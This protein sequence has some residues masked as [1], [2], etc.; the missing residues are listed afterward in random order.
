MLNE[1]QKL[2]ALI[3][4]GTELNQVNDLDLLL[5][6]L[7]TVARKF[8]NADA[9]TVYVR[10]GEDFYF[11]LLQNDTQEGKGDDAK[12]QLPGAIFRKPV[13]PDSIA[14][15]VARTGEFLNIP[16][17]HH[18]PTDAPYS[19]NVQ[20]DNE[21]GYRTGSMLT[22][23]LNNKR[24]LPLGILQIINAHDAD[25][26]IVSFSEAD[27]RIM[28]HFA[29]IAAIAL[30]RAQMTRALL[31]RM[32]RMAELRDPKE[33]G[34]HVNRV[35]SFSVALY[36]EW[37]KRHNIPEDEVVR[38]RDILRMA[39]ML[40]DAGKVG[41][42]DSILKKPGRLTD[43]ERK[44]MNQHSLFGAQLF[45]DIQSDFDEIASKVA[46]N[47]HENWDGT[48]YPGHID[49][50]TGKPLQGYE[51]PDGTA[52]GKIGDETP[53]F[54]RIVKLADVYDALSSQRC[55]KPAWDEERVLQVILEESGTS[56]DPELVEIFMENLDTM[57][58]I[59]QRY[60]E[61]QADNHA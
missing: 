12:I 29:T 22:I 8:V 41:I 2:D 55:Y 26:N 18:I 9:G 44:I 61:D 35:G 49:S 47:H 27:E 3:R 7:L 60:A 23:P 48:G 20:Y 21:S 1:Q 46:L 19:F 42:S 38:W 4:L 32:I 13:R 34:A 43:E 54:G 52:R 31:L 40:H 56:F 16:D 14:G 11:F 45:S 39:A 58:T 30:E 15:Y 50:V 37:A 5:E 53:L 36:Q 57:R 17:A 28:F 24:G 10:R 25:G 59:Q 33:T 51:N 6:H